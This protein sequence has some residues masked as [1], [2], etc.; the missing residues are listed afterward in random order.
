MRGR[1]SDTWRSQTP[2][3]CLEWDGLGVREMAWVSD[4]ERCQTPVGCL[5]WGGLV[6]G[7]RPGCLTPKG[8][9]H[10][11]VHLAGARIRAT[12]TARGARGCL[13]PGGARHL[14]AV[15]HETG[16][17]SGRWLGRRTAYGGRYPRGRVGG[18]RLRPTQEAAARW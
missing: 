6:S 18:G 8:V 11:W 15:L 14:W 10:R 9:R 12:M 13:T 3:G 5:E 17:A 4:S 7:R 1:V 16:L 2:V